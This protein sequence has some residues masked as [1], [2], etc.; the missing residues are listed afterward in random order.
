MKVLSGT[1]PTREFRTHR[2]DTVSV[3]LC[4]WE[5]LESFWQLGPGNRPDVADILDIFSDG[6]DTEVE[7]TDYAKSI[8][9][10]PSKQPHV[11]DCCKDNHEI[12]VNQAHSDTLSSEA[13]RCL[14]DSESNADAVS[15][16]IAE[17]CEDT[18]SS[19]LASLPN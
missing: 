5:L 16:A 3:P 1:R 7:I 19:R 17:A 4:L 10:D 13:F 14:E 15:N 9:D 11:T 6:S 18:S 12:T 2:G 8:V